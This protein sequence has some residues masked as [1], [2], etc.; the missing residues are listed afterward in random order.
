MRNGYEQATEMLQDEVT[1]RTIDEVLSQKY[2]LRRLLNI[3]AE[4]FQQKL[5]ESWMKS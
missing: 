1:I 5:G 2:T 4:H 3:S